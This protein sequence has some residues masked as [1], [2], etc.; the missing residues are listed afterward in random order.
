[1][2]AQVNQKLLKYPKII[3][4]EEWFMKYLFLALLLVTPMAHA[5]PPWAT[6][7][8][9]GG[10]ASAEG[11][12]ALS[13]SAS[14]ATS[15]SATSVTSQV[16]QNV[17]V[18]GSE[19][20]TGGTSVNV[21]SSSNYDDYTP[22]AFAPSM[23]ATSPCYVGITG[24]MGVPGFS[25]SLGGYVYDEK[26]EWRELVRLGLS[27]DSLTREMANEMLRQEMLD[28]LTARAKKELDKEQEPR[29]SSTDWAWMPET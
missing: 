26:C 22:S 6:P 12:S 27:G 28:K 15:S 11:G 1:M 16:T 19:G 5:V 18:Q 13:N 14:S 20:S 8:G 7:Q 4:L 24:G 3:N 29:T 9:V 21:D 17:T 10:T 25:A 2:K 23:P